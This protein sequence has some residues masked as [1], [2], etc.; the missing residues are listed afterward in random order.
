MPD[1]PP[2]SDECH[3]AIA[4][5]NVSDQENRVKIDFSKFDYFSSEWGVVGDITL[6]PKEQRAFFFSEMCKYS[7]STQCRV[8]EK[9]YGR[10]IIQSH[11]P[12]A[13]LV[14]DS[15]DGTLTFPLPVASS[16]D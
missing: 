12:H 8:G 3:A 15:I 4:I 11:D 16:Q 7:T 9:E 14:M 13:L 1:A 2:G 10:L 5:A 6:K